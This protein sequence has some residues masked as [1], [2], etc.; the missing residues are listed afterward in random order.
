M[1]KYS[2]NKPELMCPIKNWASLKAVKDYADA[3]Y[4]GVSDLSLRANANVL[5]PTELSRFVKKCHSYNIK[6]Y[7][8]VNSVLYDNT[9][10]KA[11]RIIKKAKQS[12]VDAIIVWDPAAIQLAKRHKIKFFISTQAN[13]SNYKTAQFYKKLGASRIV[14]AREMTLK[15]IKELR[16]KIKNLEIETFIHGAMCISIS[17]RCILSAYLYDKSANCGNCAQPCR[18]EWALIDEENNKIISEGKYFLNSKDLCMI[19]HIPKLIKAGI[20]SFKIE[21]RIRDPRYLETTACC[22]REAIDSYF[23]DTFTKA[24]IINWEK[25]LTSVYNRGF[26]TGFYFGIPGKNGISYDKTG[27]L[28]K[29]KKILIG[30]VTHYYSKLGVAVIILDHQGLKVNDEIYIEGNTTYLKQ[31]IT[32]I[33]INNQEIKHA[34]KGDEIAIKVS[35]RVRK[36]DKIFSIKLD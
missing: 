13:V 4:F 29:T 6:A 9:I 34:K 32:S 19:A 33:Q 16:Q 3:V 20:N 11:E 14:L 17:G 12:G 15:Q 24:K 22:Y 30:H 5:K 35:S 28:S 23:D 8:T 2:S 7:L 27:N 10:K 1:K 31:K 26:S 36:N 25:R 18:K 21:G